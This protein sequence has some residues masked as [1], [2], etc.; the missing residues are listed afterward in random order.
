MLKS[1]LPLKITPKLK[2]KKMEGIKNK[3]PLHQKDNLG[4]IKEQFVL[5]LSSEQIHLEG[6]YEI[7]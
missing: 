2:K 1:D 7:E 4:G 6:D 3:N 5:L